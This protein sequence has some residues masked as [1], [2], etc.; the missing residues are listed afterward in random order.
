[1][2]YIALAGVLFLSVGCSQELAEKKNPFLFELIPGAASGVDFRNDLKFDEEFNIYTYRN[3]YNGG[4][5][6]LG[7]VNN[8]G[9]IDI[10]FTSN[11][12]VNKLYLNR[13]DWKFEDITE[14]AGV[15][16]SKA[17][18]TGV[19]MVDINGDGWLDIY[20]CNSGDVKGDNKQ[21]E[22]FI[23]NGDLTFTEAGAQYGLDNGGFSTHAS[24]FDYD[25]D[26]DLDVYLLNNSY[27][28][29]G[30][31][32]LKNNIRHERDSL[33]GD[34]L[35]EN[36]NGYFRDVSEAAGIFGSE[37]GFGLGITVGDVNNDGWEDIYVSNDFFERDYLYINN[38]DKTFS[39]Q[40]E[41]QMKSISGASMGADMADVNND[42]YADLFVTEMLPRTRDRLKTIT[43]FEDW[44]KYQYNINAGYYHQFTRNTF[45]LNNGN[46]SFS[47][48]GRLAGVEASDWSWGALIF[49]F[50]N[51]GMKDIFI[52]NGMYQD[53]TNQ[54][55]L[56]YISN[57]E[58]MRSIISQNRVDY[59]KLIDII[60]S[61]PIQNYAFLNKGNLRFDDSTTQLGLDQKGFSNGAAYGDLDNDGDLDL[62]V[63][64]INSPAF[65][66]RNRANDDRDVNYL[67]FIL[68]GEN[69]N[70]LAIGAKISVTDGET[71][72]FVEQQPTRGFE[73]SVDPRPHLGL[74]S[75]KNVDISIKW[76]SGKLTQ[77]K[78]IRVN[79][80]IEA[81]EKDADSTTSVVAVA[82]ADNTLF[83]PASPLPYN[84]VENQF[85]DFHRE[86]LLY[87]MMSTE[88]PHIS[89]GDVNGDGEDDFYVSGSKGSPGTLLVSDNS[90]FKAT[91]KAFEGELDSED[92]SSV[93]FDADGDGDMDL[94]VCSGGT[95]FNQ[96][97]ASLLDR[98]YLNDGKGNFTL[99]PQNLPS[100]AR[101][102]STSTVAAADFDRD[103]DIDLFVGERLIPFQ[104]G[105]PGSGFI[106]VN[107]GKGNFADATDAVAP[108]LIK[109]GLI[110][111]GDWADMDADGDLDL[112]IVGEYMSPKVF[113][114][115]EGK[116]VPVPSIELD[117][118]KG[119]WNKLQ[120]ADI[121]GDGDLDI[122]AGNHGRNSRFRASPQ[123]PIKLYVGDYDKNG[124]LD[125]ILTSA[126]DG[127]D[128]PFAL[129]HNL[130]DQ[131][132]ALTKKFPDY[133][134]YKN[135]TM[136]DILDPKQ[137]EEAL[138]LE[139]T[140]L[141]TGIFVNNGNFE[142]SFVSLPVEAQFAP[143]YG[144]ST[145]DYD[146]DGDLDIL[147]GG[148][149]Y[150][151]QPEAGR[152]DA[153][154]GLFLEN[155]G[156][157]NFQTSGGNRG[158]WV[159]GEIRD[160]L[161]LSNRVIVTRNNDSTVVFEY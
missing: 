67:Q 1:M 7:D 66:Y 122:I 91:T 26:G 154:Y 20:V 5:V 58:V 79:Q 61:N 57:E 22:L 100:A 81:Y 42:G 132:K 60:P 11:I 121:D 101:Y 143:V 63:N 115:E 123:E 52:A 95:E 29:I 35:L 30:S 151:V 141:S 149:L 120:M 9:L 54:D 24:F 48:I 103:G 117:Q 64:N 116:L 4:G 150:G 16:G 80:V 106:L 73:S 148:N 14:D 85:V 114:N 77:L 33:G 2:K 126:K 138:I 135:A 31:F 139:V 102:V 133:E 76:P 155:T 46:N 78:N 142:F 131:V 125:P 40:L 34:K 8:D 75:A 62:V 17:W 92:M 156:D 12:A 147:L 158:F 104:F 134:S 127:K 55:Y 97:S 88:G 49:D 70:T 93:F 65:L 28:A 72:Y 56:R 51:D 36:D 6:A 23:N 3:F 160:I 124:F 37:I 145:G 107:D 113:K 84:H 137:I 140:Q 99:S 89:A 96:S 47:E 41:S 19:T 159:D 69:K 38:R 157:M 94:Y 18:S 43:T 86:R 108:G 129:R 25:K 53:L 112:V 74:K 144:I 105:L 152:Y 130:L 111:S 98:L 146:R 153:S 50:D 13:G 68:R 82:I 128:Y 110:T 45:Q 118:Q 71:T 83:N 136:S 109:L 15:A 39:E 21:N 161:T 119:W 90:R 59:K 87:H 44:N 32:N 27:K 10:Y